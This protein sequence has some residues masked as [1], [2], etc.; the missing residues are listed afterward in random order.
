MH[1][2]LGFGKVIDN[3]EDQVTAKWEKRSIGNLINHQF[4]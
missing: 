4:I 2:E 3:L 1:R